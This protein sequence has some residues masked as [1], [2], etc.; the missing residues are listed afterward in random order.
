MMECMNN[1]PIHYRSILTIPRNV[2][3]GLEL[4]LEK[5]S[6]ARVSSLVKSRL[7]NDWKVC[8]D[9][10]LLK[11]FN[12]E[13]N[14]PPLYNVKETWILLRKLG[15]LLEEIKPDYEHCSFQ[16]NLDGNLLK[17][18]SDRL[19]FLKLYAVYEDIV[20][21][22]SQGEDGKYRSSLE[23]YAYPIILHLKG[24]KGWEEYALEVFS[25]QKR[26][27]ICFKNKDKNLIEFR[28]P[29]ATSNP[30]LWQN[31][32]T[33][34]YYLVMYSLS[35][36]C[37]VKELD[38]YIDNFNKTYILEYYEKAHTEK[39]VDLARKIFRKSDDQLYFLEQYMGKGRAA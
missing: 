15:K 7:G 5:V 1:N 35:P 10:S 11:N 18:D 17:T 34:F 33:F 23:E 37:N 16:V 27:G 25:N 30:I 31:Y 38:Q 32:V 20:Y 14:S 21:R 19:K 29:N 28:T 26:Y 13:I 24:V 3:L 4:E 6:L 36:K 39:A 22:F 8:E 12:A 9:R 2:S